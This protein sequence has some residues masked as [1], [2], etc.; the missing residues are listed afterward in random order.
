MAKR[1]PFLFLATILVLMAVLAGCTKSSPAETQ[2][3]V[4]KVAPSTV[5]PPPALGQTLVLDNQLKNIETL[6]KG[7]IK[8]EIYW[9][10]T[11]VKA[12]DMT[13]GVQSG[14]TDMAL[15]R[16]YGEPGKLP[17]SSIGEMPG[18]SSDLWSLLW[19][20]WDLVNQEPIKTSEMA[21]YKMR[22]I[23]T[24]F[25]QEIIL[26]SKGP[27][28]TLADVKG[29]K[30][31]AGGIAAEILKSLGGV[32]LAMSPTEQYEGLLRGTIDGIASPPDAMQVFK[33]YE[34]GKYI[35]NL[36]MGPRIQPFVIN[37]DA[38]DK[39]P[40]DLQKIIT[41]ALPN[42]INISYK[43]MIEDTN[44]PVFKEMAAAGVQ[45]ID[46]SAADKAEV[47]KIRSAYADKWAADQESKGLAGKKVLADYRSL[48]AKYEKKS[49]YKK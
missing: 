40:S 4:M 33:F 13:A 6:T 16:P 32:P 47:E 43:S 2:I 35:T 9:N 3:F 28:R 31:A 49:P 45:I 11:L 20:Y 41:N 44:G 29:K 5:P 19:A 34:A 38:W 8:P 1:I 18:I 7:R 22:P 21:K 15:I 46:L 48:V 26:I 12:T 36:Y 14:L 17:L 30:I 39:L 37:Q 10:Q 24:V 23:W 25:T 27:I 42:Q